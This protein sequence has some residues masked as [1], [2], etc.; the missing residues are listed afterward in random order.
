[1]LFKSRRAQR[2]ALLAVALCAGAVG[3]VP[4]AAQATGSSNLAL[5]KVMTRNLY[6]GADLGPA[7]TAIG[8]CP[9]IPPADCQNLVL[10][11]NLTIWNQVQ[12]TNF[13]AR[14][15][16]LAKEID[17]DDPYLIGLQE[18]AL[19]RSGPI[20][21]VKDASVVDYDFL[22]TLLAELSAPRHQL[23]GGGHP[24]GGR[25]REPGG[26]RDATDHRLTMRDV[27]SSAPTCRA[28]SV[29]LQPAERELLELTFRPDPPS[30][31]GTSSSSAAGRRSTSS[32]SA[33]RS[34]GSWT[35][36]SSRWRRAS[37][38]S[39]RRSWWVPPA[40]WR[41]RSRRSSRAT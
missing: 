24:A 35:R 14:A 12:A 21:G 6:L 27:F 19:W 30:S 3:V 9:F 23:Q 7:L 22:K 13:P 28:R 4:A 5:P 20:N 17:N 25:H 32:C 18:V 26:R 16:V 1:M 37:A 34:R 11:N 31:Y 38:T 40:R 15:K 39:R 8:T 29:V 2:R 36:T 10:T 33:T 41:A